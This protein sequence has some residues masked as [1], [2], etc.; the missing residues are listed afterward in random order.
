MNIPQIILNGADWFSQMG[1]EI[2][3]FDT[4]IY[5]ALLGSN[6]VAGNEYPFNKREGVFLQDVTV[7]ECAHLA[8]IGIAD[9]VFCVA[10][11]GAGALPLD[12]AGEASPTPT[13]QPGSLYFSGYLLRRHFTAGFGQSFEATCF[14][15]AI[16][17]LRVDYIAVF[18]H[19][20]RLRHKLASI[21]IRTIS[22]FAL[23]SAGS[24]QREH[25]D[26]SAW[27]GH[28]RRGQCS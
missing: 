12:T 17:S 2:V 1:E 7:L 20:S 13:P 28:G 3:I 9:N 19:H 6:G 5:I 11:R 15:V 27:P 22:K 10:G 23:S 24:G 21:I 14:Q 4:E 8:F 16:N 26:L 25:R 18:Q